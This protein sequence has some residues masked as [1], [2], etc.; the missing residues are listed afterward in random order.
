MQMDLVVG[1]MIEEIEK[2]D[3]WYLLGVGDNGG[4][5]GYFPG[6]SE[7]GVIDDRSNI[8][9]RSVLTR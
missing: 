1:E 4:K 8:P 2:V 9:Q 6:G 7:R 5:R 3:G